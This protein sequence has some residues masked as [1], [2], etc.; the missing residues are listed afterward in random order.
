VIITPSTDTSWVEALVPLVRQG[1]VPTV[2]LLEPGSFGGTE[3]M[4]AVGI[5]LQSLGITYYEIDKDVLNLPE[6][7]PGR[8]GQWEWR[9]LGTGKAIAVKRDDQE[10]RVE[11]RSLA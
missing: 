5:A 4:E 11:W 8:Q 9:V 1:A 10:R 3:S 6:A 7:R 2:M